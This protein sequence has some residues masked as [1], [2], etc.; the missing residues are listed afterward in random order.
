MKRI[1]A[2]VV[3]AGLVLAACGSDD[4]VTVEGQWARE[5]APAQTTGA[6][7]FELTVADD[8]TL[9]AASVSSEVA[10]EAQIHEVPQRRHVRGDVRRHG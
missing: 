4:A 5:S 2:L 8:D 9:V 7:Y 10:G 3:S 1:F 6:V